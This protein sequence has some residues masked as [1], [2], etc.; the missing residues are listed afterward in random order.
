MTLAAGITFPADHTAPAWRAVWGLFLL[1][2]IFRLLDVFVFRSDEWFGEQVLTKAL[3][4]AAI[5][6]YLWFAGRSAS[7]IGVRAGGWDRAVLM[8]VA[9]AGAALVAGYTAEVIT[10]FVSGQAPSLRIGFQ[11]HS[12]LPDTAMQGGLTFGLGLL[13][14]NLLNSAMEESLFRGLMISHFL[15]RMSFARANLL[16][17]VLFGLWHV[18]WPLRGWMDGEM[19][20]PVA[21]GIAATYVISAGVAGYAW[22]LLFLA[23]RSLWSAF[24]AHTVHN[25]VLNALHVDTGLGEAPLLGVRVSVAVIVLLALSAL[26]LWRRRSQP[27]DI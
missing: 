7:A 19:S 25:S 27:S 9:V 2:V 18:I 14:G 12:L 23:T 5:L 24:T 6:A 16:Q 22:G 17:A 10:L 4:L 8:G 20:A 13:A 3:G 15:L 26:T 11:G 21:L 1:C